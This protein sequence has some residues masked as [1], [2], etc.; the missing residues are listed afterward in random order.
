MPFGK[1][2]FNIA[3]LLLREVKKKLISKCCYFSQ[4]HGVWR[5]YRAD[6][7]GDLACV[8]VDGGG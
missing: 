8:L 2:S 6:G 5:V 4:V 7:G 1:V 3:C